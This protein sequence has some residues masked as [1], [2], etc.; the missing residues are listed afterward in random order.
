MKLLI[1]GSPCTYWSIA[2]TK[3]RETEASGM[4]WELFRNYVMARDKF[5]PDYFLYENNKSMSK[6]IRE[7]ITQMLGVEPVCINS[8]LVSAQNRQRLYWVGK[9]MPDGSYAPIPVEQPEDRGILLRDVL[10]SGVCRREKGYALLGA[11]H[12]TTAEDMIRRRQRNGAAEPIGAAAVRQ[13]G[14]RIN[15]EGHS[16]DYDESIP[17]EQLKVKVAKKIKDPRLQKLYNYF[18]D[19]FGDTGL[20]LGSQISQIS[21]LY[22][23]NDFDHYI[24]EKLHIKYY[25]RYM[26]DGY[27]IHPSKKYLKFCLQEILRLTKEMGLKIN[28]KKTKISKL[29]NGFMFLNRHWKLTVKSYIKT[30]P[31]HKTMARLRRK[32]NKLITF[33]PDEDIKTFLS[34]VHGFLKFYNNERLYKYVQNQRRF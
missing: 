27:L 16:A 23:I 7:Q 8:A 18:V 11:P 24:K 12:G 9:R 4:G 15:A 26:D 33:A 5:Q 14:R 29:E 3:N 2:Q 17:H 20:G 28:L 22:Y 32:Y 21:A 6:A 10:E 25:G 34:S 31:S 19:Q 30:K 13:V 1:G